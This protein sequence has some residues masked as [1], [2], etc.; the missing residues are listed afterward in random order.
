MM[1]EAGTGKFRHAR[2]IEWRNQ[3]I[4][5]G[6]IVLLTKSAKIMEFSI[7]NSLRFGGIK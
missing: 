5:L 4:S 7:K 2:I 3:K 6:K 1:M